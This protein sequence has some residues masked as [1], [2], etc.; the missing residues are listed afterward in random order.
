MYI[1][2]VVG[3]ISMNI[4][5]GYNFVRESGTGRAVGRRYSIIAIGYTCATS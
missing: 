2:Y 4:Y 1:S 3:V 5:S